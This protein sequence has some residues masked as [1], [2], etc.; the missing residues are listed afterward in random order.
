MSSDI[1]NPRDMER[2]R[3]QRDAN[4]A[5][6]IEVD[7]GIFVRASAIQMVRAPN[8]ERPHER[9]EG[10]NAIYALAW[11]DHTYN[12]RLTP[13][14]LLRAIVAVQGRNLS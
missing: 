3:A 8:P 7:P 12:S 2:E 5:G 13:E 9:G 6:F 1:G 10:V 4:R 11:D 14:Q